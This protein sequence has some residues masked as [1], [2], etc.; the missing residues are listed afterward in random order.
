VKKSIEITRLIN[1]A[2]GQHAAPSEPAPEDPGPDGPSE[3]TAAPGSPGVCRLPSGAQGRT[4]IHWKET[5]PMATTINKQRVLVNLLNAAAPATEME[6][7]PV[8]EQFIFGVC[9]ENATLEQARQAYTNLKT[10]FFD[11]NEIR[12]SST[13]E[14]E[15]ALA[16]LSDA[17]T[18][19]HRVI[20]FL[21][22]VFETSFSFDLEG[23]QKKGM[24]QASKRLTQFVAANEYVVSWVTQR[25][26]GGHA[27]PVDAPTLRSARRLGLLDAVTE[28][29]DA[30]RATLEHLI[31]KAKG[32]QFADAISHLAEQNCWEEEPRCP[33]CPM[34]GDCSFG[35]GNSNGHAAEGRSSRAKPR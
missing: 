2:L 13:R 8:L 32:A 35:Q 26:L 23:L 30:A 7:L 29:A 33:G 21:N 11:W 20:S 17:E 34:A 14:I 16:G 15:E 5:A 25:S 24:K 27:I 9:R 3:G 1:E 19:A 28:D 10:Q 4:Y 18:R 6:P 12:V 31:P 22:E